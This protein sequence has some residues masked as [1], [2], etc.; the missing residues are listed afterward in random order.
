MR[1]ICGLGAIAIGTSLLVLR[2]T[3]PAFVP[4]LSPF[5]PVFAIVSGVAVLVVRSGAEDESQ[6]AREAPFLGAL[7]FLLIAALKL[8]GAE[9]GGPLWQDLWAVAAGL[10]VA[11][12]WGRRGPTT[13]P[14]GAEHR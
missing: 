11:W 3:V 14:H 13:T 2:R 1:R 4:A 12:C 9:Q 7:L 10:G 6:G 8:T 5:W